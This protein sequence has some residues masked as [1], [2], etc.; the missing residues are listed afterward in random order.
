[1]NPAP[2]KGSATRDDE[3]GPARRVRDMTVAQLR[4]FEPDHV[5]VA[6]FESARFFRLRRDEPGFAEAVELL[7]QSL[8]A[9]HRVRITFAEAESDQIVGVAAAD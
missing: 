9:S 5:V 2:T 6:F 4:D 8:A 3:H 7:S 1:M